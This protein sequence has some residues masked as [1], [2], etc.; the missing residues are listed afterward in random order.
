MKLPNNN[1]FKRFWSYIITIKQYYNF[2]PYLSIKTYEYTI[3]KNAIPLIASIISHIICIFVINNIKKLPVKMS[4]WIN[5]KGMGPSFW[6]GGK[7][8]KIGIILKI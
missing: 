1:V 2:R 7:E 4:Y 6:E 3:K 8:M 5:I